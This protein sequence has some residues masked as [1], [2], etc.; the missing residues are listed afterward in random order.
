LKK[1]GF[2]P[3]TATHSSYV[4]SYFPTAKLYPI[5]TSRTGFSL[6]QRRLSRKNLLFRSLL[7]ESIQVS[8]RGRTFLL[9]SKNVF[10]RSANGDAAI[11][12]CVITVGEVAL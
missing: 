9:N 3:I 2:E 5:R 4:T 7:E 8:S 11:R 12:A 10:C 6:P 1:L